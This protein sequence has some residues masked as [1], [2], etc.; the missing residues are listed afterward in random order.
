[1]WGVVV[2]ARRRRF[3]IFASARAER[4]HP[5]GTDDRLRRRIAD[6]AAGVANSIH[7]ILPPLHN[8]ERTEHRHRPRTM[9]AV[10]SSAVSGFVS[11]A[12]APRFAKRTAVKPRTSILG[13][14]GKS[15]IN[16]LTGESEWIEMSDASAAIADATGLY[17]SGD[18]TEAVATL[19]GALKLGGSGTRRD[20]SKPAEL[21]LGEQQAVYYNLSCAHSKLGDNDKAL[22]SLELTLRA[23][24]CS[25]S[26]YGFGKA[27]EDYDRLMR[28]TGLEN[29][30]SDARF[31]K[32]VDTFNV[33]PNELQ[34]QLDPSQ[35]VI[36]RA[37]KMW[38]KKK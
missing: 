1:M 25:A 19:E 38:G 32:V 8:P 5:N 14:S 11:P 36:G 7:P 6:L 18:Y 33:E 28:D 20:R 21:S 10:A 12:A 29:V 17:E 37:M 31:K 30:R 13:R 35:S 16:E 3:C 2:V 24:Y 27:N 15:G 26:L 22:K 23:G 4:R 34:L 9:F